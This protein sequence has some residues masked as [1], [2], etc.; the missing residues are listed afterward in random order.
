MPD[1]AQTNIG[2]LKIVEYNSSLNIKD[3][4]VSTYEKALDPASDKF[5]RN[6]TNL[7]GGA[8]TDGKV[9]HSPLTLPS[10]IGTKH[11]A[12]LKT[13]LIDQVEIINCAPAFKD[14]ND[15]VVDPTV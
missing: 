15:A 11:A 5:F 8:L 12:N 7:F 2:S 1:T 9:D 4:H 6:S 13:N 10:T 14:S 3:E